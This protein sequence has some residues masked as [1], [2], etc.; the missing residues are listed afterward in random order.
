M[1]IALHGVQERPIFGWGQENYAIV[2]DKYYD[3]RMYAQE[4][5]FDRV[6]NS[7]FDWLIA[8]G[9]VGLLAYLSIFLATL[10]TLW[11]RNRTGE[12]TFTIAERSILTGL[13]AGYF[14]HNL[15]VFDNVTSYI[16]FGTILG[17]IVWRHAHA[18]Q[19]PAIIEGEIVQSNM[20]PVVGLMMIGVTGI[21][22]WLVNSVPLAQNQILLQ[23]ISLRQGP[24]ATLAMIEQS[25]AYGSYGT[26]EAREQLIQ[27]A[28]QVVAA[29]ETQ[30]PSA[31]KQQFFTT[32]V[33][34]MSTQAAQSPLDARF[35]LFIGILHDVAGDLEGGRVALAHAHDLSPRKQSI[36]YEQAINAQARGD[37]KGSVALFKS[38][39]E[40]E[41]SNTQALMYYA[42]S[43]VRNHDDALADALLAPFVAHGGTTNQQL[44]SAYASRAQYGKIIALWSRYI[45]SNPTDAGAYTTLA[46][47]YYQSGDSAG[48]VHTLHAL[49]TA[50]P[51]STDQANA[52]IAEI[53][54]GVGKGK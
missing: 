7:I 53:Q 1:G 23:A 15:T 34:E 28:Q 10:Y 22:M 39:Y 45:E 36:I 12:H 49:A 31:I 16:L 51:S 3:P 24:Q 21:V 14:V 13:L 27:V 26:Q 44:A 32:A 38:A 54:K 6:H 41:T 29:P 48:A 33:R 47:A 30:V 17:Y 5:W 11:I 37:A 43:A 4:P 9:I 42:S 2:F 19:P 20:L 52:M 40:L 35:P 8:G 18:A 50:V 25:I 46:V